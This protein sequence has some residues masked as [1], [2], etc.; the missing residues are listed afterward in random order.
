MFILIDRDCTEIVKLYSPQREGNKDYEAHR[1]EDFL[2]PSNN[3]Y[4]YFKKRCQK[5]NKKPISQ[6]CNVIWEFLK[7]ANEI[8][9][10]ARDVDERS[11]WV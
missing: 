3:I 11:V 1:C 4:S 6:D 10:L 2:Q 8:F 9:P 7:L 5:K